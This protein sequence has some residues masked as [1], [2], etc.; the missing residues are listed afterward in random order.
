MILLIGANQGSA[1]STITS[2]KAPP[3]RGKPRIKIPT[4][5]RQKRKNV[6]FLLNQSIIFKTSSPAED[7]P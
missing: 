1:H 3:W 5:N 6:I 7:H 2:Q 4:T